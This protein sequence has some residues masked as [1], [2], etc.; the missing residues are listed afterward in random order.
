MQS[1]KKLAT[2]DKNVTTERNTRVSIILAKKNNCFDF[3]DKAS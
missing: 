1:K 3:I 2:I